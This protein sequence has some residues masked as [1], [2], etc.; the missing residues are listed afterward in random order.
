MRARA[1]TAAALTALLVAGCGSGPSEDESRRVVDR[2]QEAVAA[3]DAAAA[4]A[5]LTG[6]LRATLEQDEGKPC[7]RALPELGLEGGGHAARARVY[8]TSAI[9]DVAGGG[10]AFLDETASGWRISAAGCTRSGDRYS[11]LLED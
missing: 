10:D 11:C 7:P 4:C 3:G 2:F 9:V 1:A 5:E 8:L 6:H